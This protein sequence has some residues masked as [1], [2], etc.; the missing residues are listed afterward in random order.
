MLAA[1][2]YCVP[3][4][5]LLLCP[6]ADG[7]FAG[8]KKETG[9]DLYWHRVPRA[10]QR[11]AGECH[12]RCDV[13]RFLSALAQSTGALACC[14]LPAPESEIY[15][16]TCSYLPLLKHK[17]HALSAPRL[18]RAHAPRGTEAPLTLNEM[19]NSLVKENRSV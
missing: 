7:D 4:K 17:A 16:I 12:C 2:G 15:F 13:F 11:R 3:S 18:V 19:L 8:H 5:S 10:V 6:G 14:F 9:A 1:K